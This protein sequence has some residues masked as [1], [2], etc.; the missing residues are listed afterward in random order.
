MRLH[1]T[2]VLLHS[3][4]ESQPTEW[5]KIVVND[6]SDKELISKIR[7]YKTQYQKI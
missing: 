7:R 4:T 3:E 5:E 6:M 2:T 1:Q